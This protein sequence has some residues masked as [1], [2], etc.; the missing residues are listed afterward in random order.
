MTMSEKITIC[1]D[2]LDYI[3]AVTEKQGRVVDFETIYSAYKACFG[4]ETGLTEYGF[5][6]VFD[7]YIEAL[8]ETDIKGG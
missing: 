8:V 5:K 3:I 7:S 6:V 2:A 4:V 1:K